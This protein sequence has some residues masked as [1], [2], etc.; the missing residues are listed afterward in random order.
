MS[1]TADG[2][3]KKPFIV[4]KEKREDDELHKTPGVIVQYSANRWMNERLTMQWL[5]YTCGAFSFNQ[6]LLVWDLYRCQPY[7]GKCGGHM[8]G[9]E[10][11][12]MA[13]IPGA[14]QS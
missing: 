4:F 12:Y 1:I 5:Q 8:Q 11:A 2:T 3:K 9:N 6:R 7:H 13:V 14:A 10:N